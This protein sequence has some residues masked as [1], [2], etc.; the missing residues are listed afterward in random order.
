MP[1]FSPPALSYIHVT[2]LVELLLRV[3]ERG[4]C[5]P[6]NSNGHP[7][8]G[9]YFAV[10]PE[11]PTYAELGRIVRPML[12]RPRARIL[13]VPAPMAWCVAGVSECLAR[14]QS[15]ARELNFDKVREALAPSWACSGEVASR[16]LGFA[17][18][19]PLANRLQE[20]IDW[21]GAH[22]WL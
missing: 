10:G 21:Y 22:G 2:D 19:Q 4:A 5:V 18:A 15:E 13:R 9:R 11:Y 12:G 20:T 7:A 6:A 14:L 16:E 8:N 1:G 3:A 17:P